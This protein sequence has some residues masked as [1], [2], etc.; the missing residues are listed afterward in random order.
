M[1]LAGGLLVVFA[2][3]AAAASD[4]NWNPGRAPSKGAWVLALLLLLP[5]AVRAGLLVLFLGIFAEGYFRQ[6]SRIFDRKPD[7][8]I[9]PSGIADLNP[10]SPQAILWDDIV[11]ITRALSGRSLFF[12]QTAVSLHFRAPDKRPRWIPTWLWKS[13]PAWIT[14]RHIVLFPEML[15]MTEEEIFKIVERFGG[16]FPVEDE[17]P[18]S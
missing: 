18:L 6:T 4:P 1:L 15:G 10:W 9:G 12:P 13:L 11:G 17:Q 8:V 7:F 5:A 16:R 3:F 14:E 2:F